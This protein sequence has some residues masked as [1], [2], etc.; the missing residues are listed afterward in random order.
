[1]TNNNPPTTRSVTN[2]T[3]S[4]SA[5]R[6]P[7]PK[8]FILA[9]EARGLT[10]AE[11]CKQMEITQSTVSKIEN[12][13]LSASDEFVNKCADW[14]GYPAEFFYAEMTQYNVPV[15]FFRKR[16]VI[17]A[18]T[19]KAMQAQLVLTCERV[20]RLIASCDVP[21]MAFPLVDIEEYARDAAAVAREVRTQWNQPS[22]PIG[23]LVELLE[24]KGILVIACD[25]GTNKVDGLSI[26]DSSKK[27]PPLILIN[28]NMPG[29][30]QR[31]TLAHELAH[32][33]LHHHL[34]LPPV[35]CEEE[36][37]LFAGEFLAPSKEIRPY[38]T[39]VTLDKLL[40]LKMHWKVS[41]ASLLYRAEKMGKVNP[42]RCRTMWMTFGKYGW[43]ID[44]PGMVPKEE[45]TLFQ[46]ILHYHLKDL[47]YSEQ[48]LCSLLY[49]KNDYL[50][51][52]VPPV[53]TG[54]RVVK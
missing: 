6:Q 10:Q 52:H 49:C 53:F 31:F 11:L 34:N 36:A 47:Q 44:E 48:D 1:M 45:P 29:D 13:Q 28:P 33:I 38:L 30:R 23:N 54:L 17:P 46:E 43:R 9:R 19:L 42:R 35:E 18:P 20:R 24:S 22:G 5:T 50:H 26:Y 41:M 15:T 16:K 12:G 21:D 4:S 8:M 37:D 27:I 25:F 51:K 3:A 32:L 7:N 14:F 39:D 40:P 2:S